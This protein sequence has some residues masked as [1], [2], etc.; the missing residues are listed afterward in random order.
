MFAY[1]GRTPIIPLKVWPSGQSV[2]MTHCTG[3]LFKRNPGWEPA[4][5]LSHSP[6]SEIRSCSKR[7]GI[8]VQTRCLKATQQLGKLLKKNKQTTKT[9]LTAPLFAKALRFY[10]ARY[11]L[12][13]KVSYCLRSWWKSM[14]P[15]DQNGGVKLRYVKMKITVF[16]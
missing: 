5:C 7:K 11:S 16:S 1:P 14:T 10:I 2:Q 15:M 8:D 12:V 4:K 9:H 6:N 3:P 13:M